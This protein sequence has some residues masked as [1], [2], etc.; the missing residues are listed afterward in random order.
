V[1]IEM[2]TF[3]EFAQQLRSLKDTLQ[4]FYQG[5]IAGRRAVPLE[6]LSHYNASLRVIE[7]ILDDL[8]KLAP[9][10]TNAPEIMKQIKH[11]LGELGEHL[12]AL[13]ARPAGRGLVVNISPLKAMADEL[14]RKISRAKPAQ[15]C[16]YLLLKFILERL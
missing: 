16:K 14:E 11:R 2:A 10:L 9:D 13:T 15:L 4:D 6:W 8:K 12:S 1:V 3:Q 5:E 7:D